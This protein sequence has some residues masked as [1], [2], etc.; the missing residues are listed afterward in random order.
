MD[1]ALTHHQRPDVESML[2]HFDLPLCT[3][4]QFALVLYDFSET[5]LFH[6]HPFAYLVTR[7]FI[8]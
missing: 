7:M 3:Y 5:S 4:K 8:N 1:S 2:I 6:F